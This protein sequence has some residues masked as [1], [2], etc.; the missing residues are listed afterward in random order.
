[1]GVTE[2]QVIDTL[3]EH[4]DPLYDGPRVYLSQM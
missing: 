2:T 4:I 1:M 3:I